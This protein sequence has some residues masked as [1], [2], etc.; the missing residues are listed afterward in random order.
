MTERRRGILPRLATLVAALTVL[1]A[2]CSAG[3]TQS[4]T[5]APVPTVAASAQ[6][7]AE[8]ATPELSEP[9]ELT[10]FYPVLVPGPI[11]ETFDTF[12]A[13]FEEANPLI[14]IDSVYSGSYDETTAKIQTVLRGGGE[15]P[16]VAIIGNQHTVMYADMDAIVP[17]DGFIAEAGGTAFLED[18]YEG[19]LVNTKHNDQTW[20]IPF[21]RSTPVMYW[22][23]D[24]FAA[25]GLDPDRAPRDY[26]ELVDFAKKLTKDGVWGIQIPSDIDAWVVQALS[27]GNGQPWA[28]DTANKV[29]FDTPALVSTLSFLR[30]LA[31]QHGVMPA[32][33]LPWGQ[34]PTEFVSGTTAM[35]FHTTG[36]LTNIKAQ[37]EG[38]FDVGVG[39]LPGGS[40]GYGVITGGGNFAIFKHAS[41]DKQQAAWRFIE[42]MSEPERMGRWNAATGY[43]ATRKSAWETTAMREYLAR[44]PEAAIAR[45]QLQY[46]AKQMMTHELLQVTKAV[47]DEIQAALVGDRAPEEAAKRAQ[48]AADQILADFAN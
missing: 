31:T 42:F 14:T 45:D 9:V 3:A 13:E 26:D 10:F 7:S 24:L 38:K 41:P 48:E 33:V 32:G 18:F 27:V 34:Q 23:K 43:V 8:V 6:A 22:N 2:A 1:T 40:A 11:T 28:T 4:A 37:A 5:V 30:D 15:L 25:A 20:S 46:A 21:Q 36:S 12:I 29:A 47:T 44:V 39:F 17:L 16:D 19:F 35:I